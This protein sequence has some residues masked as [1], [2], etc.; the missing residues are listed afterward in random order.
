MAITN[1]Y[2]NLPGHLVQFK[3]GGLTAVDTATDDKSGKSL[4][5]LGT[6]FDGP[7]MEPVRIDSSTVA[8]VF[9][10]E[11][12]SEGYPNGA[13]LTKYAKQAFKNGFKDVRC[14]R[15]TGTLA[16]AEIVK[17]QTVGTEEDPKDQTFT[18]GGNTATEITVQHTPI[19]PNTVQVKVDNVIVSQSPVFSSMTG[20]FQFAADYDRQYAPVS[21]DYQYYDV[22]DKDVV[23]DV[24]AGSATS[25]D[26]TVAALVDTGK[27]VYATRQEASLAGTD[28]TNGFVSIEVEDSSAPG[29]YLP[30]VEGTDYTLNVTGASATDTGVIDT[31][32]L[33][34]TSGSVTDGDKVKVVFKQ[35]EKITVTG[36]DEDASGDAYVLG[37]T[38]D[39]QETTVAY[40]VTD[41]ATSGYAQFGIAGKT[42]GTD[43]EITPAN[44]IVFKK[45][46]KWA[47]GDYVFKYTTTIDVVSKESFII[48]S[49]YAGSVYNKAKVEFAQNADGSMRIT[50]TKPDDKLMS[51]ADLPF[52][53][54]TPTATTTGVKTV[55]QLRDQLENYAMNNVFEIICDDENL[56]LAGFP[57]GIYRLSGGTDGVNPTMDE[58]FEALSGKRWSQADADANRCNQA[59]V[60]YLKEQ[61]A[62][63]L[64]ENYHVDFIVPL[65]VYADVVPPVARALN[66]TFHDE[67]AMVCAVLTYRTKMT[68]GFIDVKPNNNT[69]LKGIQNYVE[70]LLTYDNVHYI[71]DQSG[72][73]VADS[74]GEKMDIG[75]YTSLVIGPDPI[76]VSDK[77]GRYYGSPAIAYAAL[78]STLKPESA[79]THKQIPG[80]VGM[81]YTFSNK[82]MNELVGNKMVVF[83]VKNSNKGAKNSSP[84]VVDGCTCG[85][86]NSD[87]G[88]I[89]TVKI[90]TDVVDQVREVC[91]PFLGEPNTKEQRNAMSALISKRLSYLAEQGEILYYEFQVDATLEQVIL[92]EC[93]ITLTLAVPMELRKITTT[94]ALRATA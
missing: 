88:R 49:L 84:Y 42:Y 48:R 20:R 57:E 53:Y 23:V 7:L 46:G 18:I 68:H 64:L 30:L 60:G 89:S 56:E 71:K 67:L 74:N 47:P 80:A 12:D 33:D 51:A 16:E 58:M 54:D 79:P 43:Y 10:D 90:V 31:I 92:G 2:P 38:Y 45:E 21:F 65:G 82:Q 87:Y 29:T 28:F 77:L 3:D 36:E 44:K 34:L 63:Q 61:G 52:Y 14:M 15:V 37:G 62:Y 86:P 25:F 93:T 27:E 85:A 50:F 70:K 4:L 73:V 11:V 78:C 24:T 81:R 26:I 13:T 83:M 94:V 66:T 5:L 75:W 8:K 40:L 41:S 69:T 32:T 35:A 72:N 19:V 59:E 9:G 91:D 39:G 6:A 1:L 55:G 17:S 22:E 76:F